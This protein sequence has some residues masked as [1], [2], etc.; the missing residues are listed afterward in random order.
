[1]PDTPRFLGTGLH[2]VKTSYLTND[3]TTYTERFTMDE[4]KDFFETQLFGTLAYEQ[5]STVKHITDIIQFNGTPVSFDQVVR[6]RPSEKDR[7]SC[8]T[9]VSFI[10][11]DIWNEGVARCIHRAPELGTY[12]QI[13]VAIPETC[14]DNPMVTLTWRFKSP[15]LDAMKDPSATRDDW[16]LLI[17]SKGNKRQSIHEIHG[18][19]SILTGRCFFTFP[20]PGEHHLA[21]YLIRS[22]D[23]HSKELLKELAGFRQYGSLEIWEH[24]SLNF[25]PVATGDTIAC[26]HVIVTV[27]DGIFARPLPK[28]LTTWLQYFGVRQL[29]NECVALYPILLSLTLGPPAFLIW[30]AL[31]RLYLVALGLIGHFIIGGGSPW[32]SIKRAIDTDL[33]A[34]VPPLTAEYE[35]LSYWGGKLGW[36][37]HPLSC[38]MI[39][40]YIVLLVMLPPRATLE[41]GL[42]GLIASVVGAIIW[43]MRPIF[44][45]RI[46]KSR[47]SRQ[48]ERES[49]RERSHHEKID[50]CVKA[51]QE[52]A[53][54][55]PLSRRI[56]LTFS[57]IRRRVC[58]PYQNR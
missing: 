38:I 18:I 28:W 10:L 50:A 46:S 1:M 20:N 49:K 17:I 19:A 8:G 23:G 36:L 32:P 21:A 31:K 54:Q 11:T 5:D 45:T 58:R 44:S 14:I 42:V 33:S 26:S 2:E 51:H 16:V 56:C 3:H 22:P 40:G 9:L 34:Y 30:E 57:G 13:T 35:R 15:A 12:G 41:V 55:I 27:P 24:E 39:I 7:F 43:G 47:L 29:E 6:L 52:G 48:Q 53:P 4:M 37:I 25:H